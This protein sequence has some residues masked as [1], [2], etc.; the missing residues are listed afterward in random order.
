VCE[1][2]KQLPRNCQ[3]VGVR[4]QP[5]DRFVDPSVTRR[6]VGDKHVGSSAE[7]DSWRAPDKMM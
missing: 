5:E 3:A 6:S 1:S 7:P 4:K 2:S